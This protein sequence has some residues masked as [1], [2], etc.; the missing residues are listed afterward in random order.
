LCQHVA[1]VH[2]MRHQSDVAGI[3]P[4]GLVRCWT[5]QRPSGS[6]H[7]ACTLRRGLV[8]LF[9]SA[10]GPDHGHSRSHR[11]RR[12]GH[13]RGDLGPTAFL[14]TARHTSHELFGHGLCPLAGLLSRL[15][16]LPHATHFSL[17]QE[18]VRSCDWLPCRTVP[19]WRR[20]C[21]IRQTASASIGRHGGVERDGLPARADDGTTAAMTHTAA[22]ASPERFT[23]ALR[24][25]SWRLTSS[26]IA[27]TG[28]AAAP[29]WRSTRRSE[30][31][32]AGSDPAVHRAT[33]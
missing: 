7:G 14:R 21:H 12:S 2:T 8:V 9:P 17:Q 1:W 24:S 19:R 5:V 28:V 6:G 23:L 10:P 25:P 31:R 3:E 32:T 11:G 4:R 33:D 20:T 13:S 27:A 29:Y 15:L 18:Y 22:D 26:T 16:D 30:I